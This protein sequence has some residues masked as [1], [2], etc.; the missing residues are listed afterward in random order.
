MPTTSEVPVP[1]VY[2]AH[3]CRPWPANGAPTLRAWAGR[4]VPHRPVLVQIE[5]SPDVTFGVNVIPGVV[6]PD[7]TQDLVACED[8][9]RALVTVVARLIHADADLRRGFRPRGA[10]CLSPSIIAFPLREVARVS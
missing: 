4:L 7:G 5:V 10:K 3:L 8:D 9:D 1:R 6:Q 2:L